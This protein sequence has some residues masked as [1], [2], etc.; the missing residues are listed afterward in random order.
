MSSSDPEAGVLELLRLPDL[1]TILNI[2]FGFTAILF[3]LNRDTDG[4]IILIL[5]A[6]LADGVDGAVAR[7]FE[8]GVFGE[9]LD[10]FADAISFGVAPAVIYYAIVSAEHHTIACAF[11]AAYLICGVLRLVR[12]SILDVA[13]FRGIPITAAGTFAVMSLYLTR[14]APSG[15][16]RLCRTLSSDGQQYPI[17][18]G[19]IDPGFDAAHHSLRPHDCGALYRTVQL[20]CMDFVNPAR[21]VRADSADR[22]RAHL[23][24]SVATFVKLASIATDD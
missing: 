8:S 2:L 21:D 17:P 15:N 3:V 16:R 10:S 9:H 12:F 14:L 5:A 24:R 18:K 4:A 20:V 11:S 13:E 6:A 1:V 22:G 7:R 19:Q 23:C